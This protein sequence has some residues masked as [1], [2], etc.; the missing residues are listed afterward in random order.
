MP[1]KPP[2]CDS[3][4]KTGRFRFQ[5]PDG[6]AR[7]VTVWWASPSKTERGMKVVNAYLAAKEG[8]DSAVVDQKI[9]AVIDKLEENKVSFVTKNDVAVLE[10]VEKE[11]AKKRNTWE[12]KY[13]SDEEMLDVISAPK[14]VA[15]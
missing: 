8:F 5:L 6:R 13:S 4:K 3:K 11:E 15:S 10:A 7:P 14:A 9:E 1:W 12:Y 2:A